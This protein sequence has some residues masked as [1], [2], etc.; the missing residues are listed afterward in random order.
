MSTLV[1]P[2]D[3]AA[4]ELVIER[5]L[6]SFV[7][8]GLALAEIRDRRLYRATFER[9]EDYLRER[10]Q[11][12]RSHGYRLIDAANLAAIVSPIGDTPTHESQMRPLV[13]V[14]PQTARE[15]W[16]K[17]TAETDQPTAEEIRR[18]TAQAL[19]GLSPANQR[20]AIE[21][22]ERYEIAR[23]ERRHSAA[24]D[25]RRVKVLRR[26]ILAM[27]KA[28]GHLVKEGDAVAGI[29]LGLS[30]VIEEAESYIAGL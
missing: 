12:G 5:G 15:V 8:V 9:F 6:T 22:E 20:A 29:A 7:A 11:F 21:A 28:H 14:D 16:S 4:L 1:S 26:D 10:W 19:A 30:T 17:A 25:D 18:L 13:G 27:R 3:L 2:A 23:A 24:P